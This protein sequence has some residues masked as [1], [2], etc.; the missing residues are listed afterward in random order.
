MLDRA[1]DALFRWLTAR[2]G[3]GGA[4]AANVLLGVGVL[5][6][7]GTGLTWAIDSLVSTSG[8]PSSMRRSAGGSPNS[9]HPG[10]PTRR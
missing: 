5:L 7:L 6:G 8:S 3:V 2:L 4:V 10:R 9:V 1:Y